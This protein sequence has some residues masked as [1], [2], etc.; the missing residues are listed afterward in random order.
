[1]DA[2]RRMLRSFKRIIP[3]DAFIDND[4]VNYACLVEHAIELDSSRN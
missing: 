4:Y 3:G 1:M 2:G